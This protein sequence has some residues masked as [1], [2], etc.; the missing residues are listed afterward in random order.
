M[1]QFNTYIEKSFYSTKYRF[2]VFWLR[3]FHICQGVWISLLQTNSA[4]PIRHELVASNRSNAYMYVIYPASVSSEC[5]AFKLI[6]V[7]PRH[8]RV[9]WFHRLNHFT[10]SSLSCALVLWECYS[11]VKYM[12]VW[13][14]F[15]RHS[16]FGHNQ[17]H[18]ATNYLVKYDGFGIFVTRLVDTLTHFG[19]RLFC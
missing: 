9:R 12:W 2:C 3:I 17:M 6:V 18:F 13:Q 10:R 8:R 19:M 15:N 16:W 5:H 1:G 7:S 14:K 4:S 11:A